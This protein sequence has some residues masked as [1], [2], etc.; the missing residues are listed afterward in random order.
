MGKLTN[1]DLALLLRRE[2]DT[3]TGVMQKAL[4]RAARSALLWPEEAA[5]VHA[6]GNSLTTLDGIGPRSAKTIETW[7]RKPPQGIKPSI[8]EAE[9]YTL[10]EANRLLTRNTAW[11]RKLRG[12]LQMHT[13][14]SDGSGSVVEMAAAAIERGYEYISITDHTKGLSIANGLDERR[15][16][17]QG[18]EIAQV[19]AGLRRGGIPFEVL[20]STEVNLSPQG[21]V[22]MDPKALAKLDIVL[23]SFHSALRRKEDQTERYLAALR[24]PNIQILGHPQCRVYA[25]RAGLTADWRR[26]FAEAAR[27]DKAVEIDGYADRQDLKHSLLV[28][29]REEGCRISLGTDAHHPWQL[30]FM[31]LGLAAAVRAKIPADRILN[32]MSSQDL[33]TW[34]TSVRARSGSHSSRPRSTSRTRTVRARQQRSSV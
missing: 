31:D 3:E 10:A 13:T 12:D 2:A 11:R 17:A 16:S 29:A 1:R 23:G 19:N 32:F 25:Y 27:L 5:A 6:K 28:I 22:D 8:L 18:R 7:L 26:V 21:E 20:H 14:W 15:L 9:F 24:N 34:V 4:K 33:K 30:A